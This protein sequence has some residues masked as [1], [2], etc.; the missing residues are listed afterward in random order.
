MITLGGHEFAQM[1]TVEVMNDILI[2]KLGIALD[3]TAKFFE[4]N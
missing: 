4:V 1:I 2:E 3:E